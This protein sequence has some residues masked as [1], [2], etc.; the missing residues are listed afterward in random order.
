MWVVLWD[1]LEEIKSDLHL[2][3]PLKTKA[4]ASNMFLL[5]MCGM[6]ENLSGSELH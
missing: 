3:H 1:K 2:V 4:I 5:A 6:R